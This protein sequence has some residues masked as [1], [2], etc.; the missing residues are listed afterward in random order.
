MKE[1]NE[2]NKETIQFVPSISNEEI[3]QAVNESA[4]QGM[5]K[6]IEEFFTG[7]NSPFREKVKEYL[8]GQIPGNFS[9]DIAGCMALINEGLQAQVQEIAHKA[10]AQSYVPMVQQLLTKR[11]DQVTFSDIVNAFVNE[12]DTCNEGLCHAELVVNSC[13]RTEQLKLWREDDGSDD[14]GISYIITFNPIKTTDGEKNNRYEI[15]TMPMPDQS[16]QKWPTVKCCF[17]HEGTKCTM[18]LP[19]GNGVLRD[20]FFRFIANI[21]VFNV[22]VFK[23]RYH[24]DDIT[25]NNDSY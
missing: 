25:G 22:P 14:D 6:Q 15:L 16:W 19:L 11:F 1:K 23:D 21:V 24:F 12:Y 18:H 17:E 2:E 7:Y 20:S 13:Y 3:Q 5:L 4:R 9:L 8:S 10:I